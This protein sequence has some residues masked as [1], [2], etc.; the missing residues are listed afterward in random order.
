M[1]TF[2]FIIS[3]F[4][5]SSTQLDCTLVL[6]NQRLYF[7]INGNRYI[8]YPTDQ[9]DNSRIKVEI[10]STLLTTP[11]AREATFLP[12]GKIEFDFEFSS[13]CIGLDDNVF[14]IKQNP[15]SCS[16][17]TVDEYKLKVLS[18]NK[19]T[20]TDTESFD[21]RRIPSGSCPYSFFHESIVAS[22]S[23]SSAPSPQQSSTSLLPSSSSPDEMLTITPVADIL[24]STRYN[25]PPSTEVINPTRST[26]TPLQDQATTITSSIPIAGDLESTLPIVPSLKD[27]VVQVMTSSAT[28]HHNIDTLVEPIEPTFSQLTQNSVSSSTESS[29][30]FTNVAS[31]T[32]SIDKAATLSPSPSTKNIQSSSS[33][34]SSFKPGFYAIY[35]DWITARCPIKCKRAQSKRFRKCGI[36]I[37]W[38]DEHN[39]TICYDNKDLEMDIDCLDLNGCTGTRNYLANEGSSCQNFCTSKGMQCTNPI[40]TGNLPDVFDDVILNYQIDQT[41]TKWQKEY[42]P[43]CLNSTCVEYIDVPA[44]VNCSVQ[45]PQ[46]YRRLC[47]CQEKVDIGFGDWSPWSQC[48]ASCSGTRKRTRQCYDYCQGDDEEIKKCGARRCPVHGGFSNWSH[49][50]RCDRTCGGGHRNKTRQCNQPLPRFRGNGCVG[51]KI[52]AE[53]CNV[54]FCPVDAFWSGW[55][56][57]SG[58]DKPC[59]NGSF[60]RT[61]YCNKALYGGKEYCS[62]HNVSPNGRMAEERRSCNEFPCTETFATLELKFDGVF[63]KSLSNR[64]SQD[65]KKL[66]E[67]LLKEFNETFTNAFGSSSIKKMVLNNVRNGSIIANTTLTFSSFDSFQFII[68]QDSIEIENSIGK[69]DLTAASASGLQTMYNIGPEVPIYPPTNISIQSLDSST[70]LVTWEKPFTSSNYTITG[71]IVFFRSTFSSSVDYSKYATN[72]TMASLTGLS[73]GTEY[74]VRIL[75]YTKDGN[76]VAS[77]SITYRTDELIPDSAPTDLQTVGFDS[78]SIL[79]EWKGL[80]REGWNGRPIGYRINTFIDDNLIKNESSDFMQTFHLIENL[81]PS[82]RYSFEVCAFNSKGKG[83]CDRTMGSTLHSKP[84]RGPPNFK[85][86]INRTHDSLMLH[87]QPPPVETIHGDFLSY[88][89]TWFLQSP[90]DGKRNSISLHPSL[91]SYHVT[92]LQP[93]IMYRLVIQAVNQYGEGVSS[94]IIE[95]TCACPEKVSTSYYLLS[96]Y[97]TQSKH[98][99]AGIFLDI[100]KQMIPSICGQCQRSN[101]VLNTV[102]DEKHNGRNAFAQKSSELQAVQEIDEY[103]DLTFPIIGTKYLDVF[104]DYPFISII[105]HP[106]VVLIARDKLWNEIINEMIFAILDVWPL[107]VLNN[108]IML[109][110]G[111]IVWLL[112]GRI[113]RKGDFSNKVLQGLQEGWYWAFI[114]Q[115]THG[116]GD[117]KP[118]QFISRLAAVFYIF[119]ALVMSSLMVGSIVTSITTIEDASNVKIYGT[120]IGAINGSFEERV[121]LLRNGK[122]NQ[123]GVYFTT[124]QLRDVLLARE[125]EGILV[126]AYT[127]GSRS[128]LFERPELRAVNVYKY[129]RS[130]GFVMSG[131]LVNLAVESRDW[132]SANQQEILRLVQESTVRMEASEAKPIKSIFSADSEAYQL[133]IMVLLLCLVVATIVGVVYQCWKNKRKRRVSALRSKTKRTMW[134]IQYDARVARIEESNEI[135][136]NF[137]DQ[138]TENV[139][140]LEEEHA[141]RLVQYYERERGRCDVAN[142]KPLLRLKRRL[143]RS[144]K[145]RKRARS[146]IYWENEGFEDCSLP[147]PKLRMSVRQRGH[148]S[149]QVTNEEDRTWVVPFGDDGQSRFSDDDVDSNEGS[150]ARSVDGK[151]SINSLTIE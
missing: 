80:P 21:F 27:D 39:S 118:T 63:T 109:V 10:E 99:A 41:H 96:P 86:L 115:G 123:D 25:L 58:C 127:A 79:L 147:S 3:F 151:I 124:D 111:F 149:I 13:Y 87:W 42:A 30:S 45:P 53:R 34:A 16:S 75:S 114:T 128:Q 144:T 150:S 132:V 40:Q 62:P 36:D 135:I 48:S 7:L 90:P 59:N 103:T 50:T 125:V 98:S 143:F 35:S 54:H 133:S 110:A 14:V 95:K 71:Y 113:V 61:R 122:M 107:V 97:V 105:Q 31:A 46:G 139:C 94:E 83:P 12:D 148:P 55:T 32:L 47:Y 131:N 52:V 67:L 88:T 106:G 69:L 116:Y 93:N 137:Y 74:I 11:R 26:P 37:E 9:S 43:Y 108:L 4:V 104:M 22:T 49:W 119:I 112:D 101:G 72:H 70:L 76:G 77:K 6:K 85:A 57:W 129:L 130:Y 18:G 100:L 1:N 81:V 68:I 60:V 117:F 29:G 89:L 15:S 82:S 141:K 138:F 33:S 2:S 136:K 84:T 146:F 8:L 28:A 121:G 120:K 24:Q 73:A 51:S 64:S 66:E 102:I 126:D 145:D 44:V 65:F 91:T 38:F 140:N 78:N 134:K 5:I 20:C 19:Y 92:G 17:F 142:M 23:S 56:S